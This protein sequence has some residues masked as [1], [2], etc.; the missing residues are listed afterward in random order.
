M[1]EKKPV[2]LQENGFLSGQTSLPVAKS[3]HLTFEG[4]VDE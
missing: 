3:D 4:D 2:L 1:D